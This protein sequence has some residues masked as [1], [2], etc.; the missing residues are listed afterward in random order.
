MTTTQT[1][2][3]QGKDQGHRRPPQRVIL[4]TNTIKTQPIPPIPKLVAENLNTCFPPESPRLLQNRRRK[5]QIHKTLKQ[6]DQHELF[7]KPL[8]KEFLEDRYRRGCT[9]ST[10]RSYSTAIF[11]F[12]SYMKSNGHS[13]V[14]TLTRADVGGFVEHLQDRGLA[15]TTVSGRLD[16]VYNFLTFIEDKKI[17]NPKILKKKLRIK[18]PACLPRAMDPEDVKAFVSQ[19]D[20][21]RSRAMFLTLLR[22]GMR[23]GELL[24]TRVEQVNLKQNR[25]DIYQAMKTQI[26]RVVHFTDDARDALSVWLEMGN[27]EKPYI[28]CGCRDKPLSYESA[29]AMFKEYIEKAGISH[30]GYTMHCLRHTCASELLNAGM[31]LECLQELLGHKNIEMTRRYARLTNNT[32]KKEYFKAMRIIEKGGINGH[33]RRDYKLPKTSKETQLLT[34]HD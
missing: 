11:Q 5:K 4:C 6:L 21:P 29:R 8:V 18:L 9:L 26:G 27:Q 31:A 14:E 16:N 25:I 7:D 33:Y 30:K 15:P 34:P 2:S 3:A 17:I 22:T 13:S 19:L 12:F 10:I 28:F 24:N 20:Q 1:T 32:R 23:I